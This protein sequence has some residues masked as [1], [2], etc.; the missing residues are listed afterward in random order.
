MAE[1]GNFLTQLNDC[2][3]PGD[4]SVSYEC[5][6]CGEGATVWTGSAFDCTSGYILL[7]HREFET[8]LASGTCNGRNVTAHSIGVLDTNHGR[9][10]FSQLNITLRAGVNN[11]TIMCLYTDDTSEVV[12][13]T[14]TVGFTT[15]AM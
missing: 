13:N 1:S 5:A 14:Y 2:I 9:C 7:R 11:K 12:V 15:G 8:G 4:G 6:I 3:C 10:F